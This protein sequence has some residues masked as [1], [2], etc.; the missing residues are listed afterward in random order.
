MSELIRSVQTKDTCLAGWCKERVSALSS[1]L[2]QWDQLQPLIE[3]HQSVLQGQLDIIKENLTDQVESI[4]EETEKFAIRWEATLKDLEVYFFLI[5]QNKM[6]KNIFVQRIFYNNEIVINLKYFRFNYF[7]I[8]N[9][10]LLLYNK[11]NSSS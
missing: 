5:I 2:L 11:S 4:T 9:L 8:K 7:S 1:L 6:F 3:N 10:F